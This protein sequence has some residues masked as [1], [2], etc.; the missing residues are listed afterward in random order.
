MPFSATCAWFIVICNF[1]IQGYLFALVFSVSLAQ[2][3]DRISLYKD[4]PQ[5][6][7]LSCIFSVKVPFAFISISRYCTADP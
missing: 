1:S 7:Y 4:V 6:W 2:L 3:D 5:L